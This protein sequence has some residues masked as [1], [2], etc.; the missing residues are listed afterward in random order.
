MAPID[1]EGA[2][3]QFNTTSGKWTCLTPSNSGIAPIPRSYHCICSD[4]QGTLYVHAGCPESG[5]LSDLWSFSLAS[6]QWKELS[7]APGPARGGTSIA[8]ADGKLYRMN[9]FDG[10]HEQGGSVDIYS[11]E[12]DTWDSHSYIPDNK[13]GPSPRSVSAL[14][15]IH[16]NGKTYIVTLF[17]ESDPSNLGHQGAGKMLSD[18]WAFAPASRTWHHVDT[19][20]DEAPDARGW[21][22]AD[23]AG[24]D[25]IIVQGGLGEANNR[26]GDAWSLGFV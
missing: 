23:V 3:W 16:V 21:F 1:E 26:L 19:Q 8:F 9:G 10:K 25:T 4:K 7:A 15:P 11:P 12:S 6:Q 17:G 13:S 14:L 24:P 5:R 2:L 20:G 18:V 22:A